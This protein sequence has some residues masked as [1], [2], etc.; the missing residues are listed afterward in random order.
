[1]FEGS[2]PIWLNIV[3]LLVGLTIIT[4]AADKFVDSAVVIARRTGISPMIIGATIVSLGTTLPEFSVMLLGGFLDRAPTAIGGAIGSTICNIGLIL[5]TCILLRPIIAQRRLYW[6][7]GIIMV[8]AGI[9]VW[10][11]SLDE[12]LSRVDSLIITVVLIAYIILTLRYFGVSR[13]EVSPQPAQED[14]TIKTV[15]T[16]DYS[17]KK[18]VILFIIGAGGVALGA[19]LIVENA[20]IVAGWLG[21]PELVIGLTVVAFGTSLPELVTCLTATIKRHGEIAVGNIIGA[22]ILDVLW[23]LG[24]G[25]LSFSRLEVEKQTLVLDYPAMLILMVLLVSFGIT[26][27]RLQRWQG[28]IILGVYL[29]YLSIMFIYFV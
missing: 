12:I 20:V 23:V 17:L 28:G 16:P 26:G 5:G 4:F 2:L 13:S 11:L 9:L 6:R 19:T 7:H 8:L 1:M 10:L 21:I 25:A 22:D 3:L 14:S 29:A 15:T 24:P 18:A 27:H